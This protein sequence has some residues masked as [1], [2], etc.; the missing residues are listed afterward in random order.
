MKRKKHHKITKKCSPKRRLFILLPLFFVLFLIS[1]WMSFLV[2][3]SPIDLD[4]TQTNTFIIPKGQAVSIIASRLEEAGFIKNPLAFRFIV[5][6]D[7]LAKKI[8]AGS[9]D[10]SPS[11][12]TAEVAKK[13]TQGTYDLWVTIPEGWRREEIA[14]SLS[15][16]DLDNFDKTEFLQLTV[17]LEGKLFPDTYLVP[18]QIS[19]EQLVNLFQQTFDKKIT[20][21]LAVDFKN[22]DYSLNE[23]LTMAS[24]IEREAKG[25]QQMRQVAGVL[26]KRLDIGMALQV[27]ASLQYIKGYDATQ[28]SW[29]VTPMA[30]D[31]QLTSVFN[32]YKY[33][34][35]PPSPIANPGFDAIK[36]T[37][38]PINTGALF[39]I[40]DGQGEIHFA[41]N[42]EEHN[43]NV[44]KYLR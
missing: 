36:A 43:A 5:K 6:K 41:N 31:K 38:N 33:P 2:V 3:V 37:L 7:G 19:A 20:K 21:G 11:M 16:Q 39:Y 18:R 27:D 26:W 24:I 40:H 35:L 15:I 34:G 29:W 25:Y 22:T 32:T 1:L 14:D 28:D 30:I 4:E 17:G 8:Q 23:I 9:F 12:S 10:L 13:L 44:A 42:L